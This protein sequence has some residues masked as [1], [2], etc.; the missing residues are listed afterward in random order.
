MG[1]VGQRDPP[2]PQD[3]DPSGLDDKIP[4]LRT[5]DNQAGM[6]WNRPPCW[7]TL[8]VPEGAMQDTGEEKAPSDPLIHK[9]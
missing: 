3:L 8:T 7:L 2:A 6:S 1:T 4:L 5:A 9:S